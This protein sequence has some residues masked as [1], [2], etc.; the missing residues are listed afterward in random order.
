MFDILKKKINEFIG[1]VTSKGKE[2]K[3]EPEQIVEEKIVEPKEEEIKER[4][5]PKKITVSKKP[6]KKVQKIKKEIVVEREK[7]PDSEIEE[8]KIYDIKDE[9]IPE[10]KEEIIE[11]TIPEIK[12]EITQEK[13]GIFG[14]IRQI[15]SGEPK[16]EIKEKKEVKVK[17]GV[18]EQIKSTVTGQI[19][20]KKGDIEEL[21]EEFEMGLLEGDVALEVAGEI[22]ENL[23]NRLIGKKIKK[24]ELHI[25]IQK[26]MKEILLEIT[27]QQG[28]DI[29]EFVKKCEKPAKIMFLGINGAGKTTTLAKIAYM[30]QKSNMKVVFAAADTF[31]AAA[32]EQLDNHAKKLNIKTIKRPYG[33]DPTAVVYDAVNYAKA[34]GI[35]AVLIDT[36]GRQDTN[37]DLIDELKKTERVI[38]PDLKIYI[39]ESIGGNAVVSQVSSFNDEIGLN[40]V[41]L[42][43]IDCDPKGGTIISIAKTTG[44]PILYL[45]NGQGYEDIS[46]FEPDR[47]IGNILG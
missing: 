28:I 38:K 24:K 16:E 36:A 37:K 6:K 26:E 10:T 42:T 43:K 32:I 30:L 15:I 33:S 13:K 9:K 45:T 41:I 22:K 34:H 11:E 2:K 17:I 44:L 25:E 47:I 8:E 35:D 31:R 1:K 20:I 46:K 19:E 3:E 5:E 14:Q 7:I 21:L 29:V 23:E 39:G 18:I 12:K 4:K 27:S 40:G